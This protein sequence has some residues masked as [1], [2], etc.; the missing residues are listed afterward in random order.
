MPPPPGHRGQK[1]VTLDRARESRLQFVTTDLPS[2]RECILGQG[3]A[4][5]R[6]RGHP[7]SRST[8]RSTMSFWAL[9]CET[10]DAGLIRIVSAVSIAAPNVE[11]SVPLP[12]V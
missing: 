5:W 1:L 3:P 2:G 4:E 6:S 7:P 9:T 12:S 10:V 11:S 8:I